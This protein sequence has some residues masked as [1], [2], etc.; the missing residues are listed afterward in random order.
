MRRAN[1][2]GRDPK[3]WERGGDR[4][5]LS[6]V[7]KIAARMRGPPL[8]FARISTS[9]D[10]AVRTIAFQVPSRRAAR[11][12][13]RPTAAREDAVLAA[14]EQAGARGRAASGR[15]SARERRIASATKAA[16]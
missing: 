11:S 15:R 12:Q 16:D 4:F 8:A 10:V 13:W 14:D 1:V 9:A 2:L 3:A 7:P 5:G 6:R